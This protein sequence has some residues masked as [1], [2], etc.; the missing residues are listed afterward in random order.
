MTRRNGAGDY[1]IGY[2]RPPKHSRFPPGVSGNPAGKKKG[3]RGLKTD[4][5]AE[6]DATQA[7]TINGRRIKGRRQ[8]LMI[9]T[10]AMR[11]AAGDLK[12]AQMLIPL[13][14]QAFGFEDRNTA[15]DALSAHDQALLDQ[16]L[17]DDERDDEGPP[18]D[19]GGDGAKKPPQKDIVG[20]NEDPDDG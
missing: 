16:L 1:E 12:A 8:K 2:G 4:L 5:A 20:G 11:A 19:A 10:L 13:I 3:K 6:L 15:K 7:I 9:E 18:A 17:A 14:V